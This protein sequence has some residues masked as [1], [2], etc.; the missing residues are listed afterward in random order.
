MVSATSRIAPASLAALVCVVGCGPSG[1]GYAFVRPEG[2]ERSCDDA[3]TDAGEMV[4]A[5]PD[6]L[7]EPWDIADAG[8]LTGIFAVEVM[9]PARAVTV[10]LDVRQ[11]YRLRIL[12]RDATIRTKINPCR[13]SLP[14]VPGVA[15]LRIPPR[16]EA[17]LR[18]TT[19]E[20]EGPFLSMAD[21]VGATLTMPPT[22]VV[23]GADLAMPLVDPLPTASMLDTALDEDMDGY[24]GVTIEA[25]TA[26]CSSIEEA[27]I[28][29]RT[30]VTMEG[31]VVDL[32]TIAGSVDPTL[33]QSV[34]GTSH[35]CLAA[36]ASLVIEIVEGS[37]FSALRVG[38]ADDLDGNGNVSCREIALHAPR[39]FGDFWA[40]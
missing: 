34:L 31:T 35:R 3:G 38:D 2:C 30:S 26:L 29:L 28:A 36:A 14:S 15:T 22:W 37:S 32:D 6:D 25:E 7:L 9:T 23:L 21:A 20:D 10:D 12:Q 1:D 19:I 33:E 39:L 5:G 27:Y 13:F 4:D 40:M 16:L 17:V 18:A 11:I 8:P 24:P